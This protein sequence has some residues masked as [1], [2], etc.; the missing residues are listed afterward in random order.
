MMPS[1][2]CANRGV[3]QTASWK[4][5]YLTQKRPSEPSNSDTRTP[6]TAS[7]W[8]VGVRSHQVP[9]LRSLEVFTI[10]EN[11]FLSNQ[12]CFSGRAREGEVVSL[13]IVQK[14]YT[15]VASVRSIDRSIGVPVYIPMQSPHSRRLQGPEKNKNLEG[16]PEVG[17]YMSAITSAT[18]PADAG[19]GV[20][21]LSTLPILIRQ[22][23]LTGRTWGQTERLKEL[24]LFIN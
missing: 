11:G 1:A 23:H 3:R 17:V 18:I 19:G 2:A 6:M 5:G 22:D 21:I 15:P 13:W 9:K 12:H 14:E 4:F 24:F 16:T 8:R 10:L 7:R 20:V